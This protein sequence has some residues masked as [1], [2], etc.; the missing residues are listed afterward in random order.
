VNGGALVQKKAKKG[1]GADLEKKKKKDKYDI[2]Q[3]RSGNKGAAQK[4]YPIEKKGRRR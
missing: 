1:G 2:R 4:R 3:R